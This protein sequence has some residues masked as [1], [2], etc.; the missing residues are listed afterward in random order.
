MQIKETICMKSESL[1]SGNNIINLLSAEF[2]KRMVMVKA[3]S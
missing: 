1:F 2:A 3:L